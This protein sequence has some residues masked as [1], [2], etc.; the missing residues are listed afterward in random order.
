MRKVFAINVMLAALCSMSLLSAEGASSQAATQP[1][2]PID[3]S[4]TPEKIPDEVAWLMLFQTVADGPNA[5][6]FAVRAALL[7]Q[8]GLADSDIQLVVSAAT[9][10]MSRIAAME[11]SV[12]KA[13]MGSDAATQALRSQRDAILHDAIDGLSK[14]LSP[15]AA[16]KFTR[17]VN[18]HVKRRTHIMP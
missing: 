9:D 8:S 13:S 5:P 7:R 17:H 14:R 18:D 12:P 1:T 10:A 2:Q 11:A 6:A 3:G 4:K 15:D 16:N